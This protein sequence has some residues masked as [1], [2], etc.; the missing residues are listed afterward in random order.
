MV[1]HSISNQATIR[2]TNSDRMS[3]KYITYLKV[4]PGNC[5][6]EKH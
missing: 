3:F 4:K 2:M 6:S 1:D 5:I